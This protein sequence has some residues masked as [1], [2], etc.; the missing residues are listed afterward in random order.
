M[1]KDLIKEVKA[2]VN[3]TSVKNWDNYEEVLKLGIQCGLV[4][5]YAEGGGT[6]EVLW[7]NDALV[8][9]LD[10]EI[11]MV[12]ARRIVQEFPLSESSKSKRSSEESDTAPGV[13]Q[14]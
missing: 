13:E 10:M 4:Q 9:Y 8:R 1:D 2:R 11:P 3:T 5:A 7:S 14:K 12:V 6:V